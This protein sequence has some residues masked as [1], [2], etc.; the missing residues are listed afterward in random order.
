MALVN[1][2]YNSEIKVTDGESASKVILVDKDY[3]SKTG[4]EY[5]IYYKENKNRRY[6]LGASAGDV[7]NNPR[8]IKKLQIFLKA[9]GYYN[10]GLNARLDRNTTQALKKYAKDQYEQGSF[11]TN[12]NLNRASITDLINEDLLSTMKGQIIAT[13]SE[14]DESGVLEVSTLSVEEGQLNEDLVSI[15][16]NTNKAPLA[17]SNSPF[18]FWGDSLPKLSEKEYS[19]IEKEEKL[20]STVDFGL[21]YLLRT[22]SGGEYSDNNEYAEIVSEK[23]NEIKEKYKNDPDALKAIEKYE[24]ELEYIESYRYPGETEEERRA[25]MDKEKTY[26]IELEKIKTEAKSRTQKELK[27]LQQNFQF[28]HKEALINKLVE[29][30]PNLDRSE[31]DSLKISELQE[32]LEKEALDIFYTELKNSQWYQD[33]KDS[34]ARIKARIDENYFNEVDALKV[35]VFGEPNRLRTKSV[36]DHSQRYLDT[37]YKLQAGASITGRTFIGNNSKEFR[38]LDELNVA[39]RPELEAKREYFQSDNYQLMHQDARNGINGL[40]RSP[41]TD[42]DTTGKDLLK[43]ENSYRDVYKQIEE[44]NEYLSSAD[45]YSIAYE[46]KNEETGGIETK[47]KIIYTE[48]SRKEINNRIKKVYLSIQSLKVKAEKLRENPEISWDKENLDK[49]LKLSDFLVE[50]VEN[51]V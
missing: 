16:G 43:L 23:I 21:S 51:L 10:S 36:K 32:K 12:L 25:N 8:L 46:E 9:K 37:L 19:Q 50:N 17:I 5:S 39:I 1:F 18:D 6:F 26:N 28:N 31:L 41:F 30:N 34:E 42:F 24:N 2:N 7:E 27:P 14:F 22:K 40:V 47:Q 45:K 29:D 35:K 33:Y 13:K 49:T 38:I 20:I 11:E 44:L 4:D 15:K 3:E 48:E